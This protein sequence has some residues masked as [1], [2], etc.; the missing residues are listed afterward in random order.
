M[1]RPHDSN[2]KVFAVDI[3]GS[4]A[5]Y[6]IVT[7]DGKI[8][9]KGK[10]ETGYN[11]NPEEVLKRIDG[12]KGKEKVAIAVAGTIKDGVIINSPNLPNWENYDIKSYFGDITIENDANA[13]AYGEWYWKEKNRRIL[14]YLAIG[15]GIGGGVVVDG[16]IFRGMGVATEL[17]HMVIDKEGRRCR[18]GNKGCLEAMASSYFLEERSLEIFGKKIPPKKLAYLAKKNK[19]AKSIFR[20]LGRNLGVGVSN[21]SNIFNPEIIV[22]GGGIANSYHLF[23]SSMIEEYNKRVL[24]A[25]K[26]KIK[27][28]ELGDLSGVLGI[29]ALHFKF[30]EPL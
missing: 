16:D 10:I 13:S 30:S 8:E 9:K 23:Q 15:T 5:K 20:E 1:G 14:V 7:I 22:I 18:C 12:I 4:Y 3:G 26:C 29:A 11:S 28:S 17:G 6:A 21:I 2:V 19:K 24:S 25:T 27:N